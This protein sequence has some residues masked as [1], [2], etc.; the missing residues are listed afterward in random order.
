MPLLLFI[1]LPPLLDLYLA[2]R[3]LFSS[4]LLAGLYFTIAAAA[5]VLLVR[6]AK[7]GVGEAVKML[8]AGDAPIGAAI[9]FMKIWLA[10]A[11][12]FFPGY[13]SDAIAII[14]LLLPSPKMRAARSSENDSRPLEATAE[15]VS[16][17]PN[18]ESQDRENEERN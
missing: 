10:G 16:E 14:V 6:F 4:P 15:I 18:S 5:G 8:S 12:L 9:G 13:L 11:L 3:W 2:L 7:I 1:V 17:S